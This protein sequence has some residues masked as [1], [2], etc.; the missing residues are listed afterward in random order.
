MTAAAGALA[1]IAGVLT[2]LAGVLALEILAS[3][4][5][6]PAA[7]PPRAARRRIA[8]VIPAHNEREGVAATVAAA[9]AQL[10]DIDRVIVVADNCSDD[11]AQRARPAGAVAIERRDEFRCGKGYALQFGVDHLRADPPD[12]VVFLDADCRPG[13]DALPRI[14]DLAAYLQRPV[15]ALYLMQPPPGGG[16]KAAVSAFAW[17]LMNRVRMSGLQAIAGVTR[18]TGSG[19][20]FP[21]ALVSRIA[22]ASGDIVEDLALTVA[23][24][25]AGSAPY[26]DLGAVVTSELPRA[27]RAAATQRA[28][29]ELGSLRL[30]G[31][32]V[33]KLLARGL[34][35]DW[36]ALALA[37]DLAAPPLALFGAAIAATLAL[38][39]VAAAFGF[40]APLAASAAAAGLFAGSIALAWIAYG[41]R[42][43]PAAALVGVVPYLL[44]KARIW[45]P[46]GRR[47]TKRWTRT[48]RGGE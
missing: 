36:R 45:G 46:E 9:R 24:V 33:P 37:L 48:E 21:W 30:A 28:R 34:T 25:E 7:P 18:L 29:W 23:A 47:S 6:R 35:G 26:L 2:A 42:V 27:D 31:R 5:A 3:F 32:A 4:A 41:R 15:Q 20:A 14:A 38:A 10:R 39:A 12:A 1:V 19:M 40:A 13:P 11:T 22:L 17:L 43:L 16:A 44:G 8:V